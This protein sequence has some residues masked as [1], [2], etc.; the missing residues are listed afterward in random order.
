MANV[1]RLVC[2]ASPENRYATFLY[3]QFDPATRRLV[4]SN[5]GHNPPIVLRDG[6]ALRLEAGGPP[7]GLFRFSQYVQDEIALEP[8]DLLVLFT[9]GVSEAENPAEDEWGEDALIAAAGAC[10]G[11]PP[12]EVIAR[13]M[14]AADDFAAGAPQHDD[15]TLVVA[16]VLSEPA[17][18]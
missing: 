1:N 2:D 13:I 18:R 16:K 12:V 9:D 6:E 15:M 17:A 10:T 7:V 3:A 5:G 4:Y 11:L 8:G 14:R